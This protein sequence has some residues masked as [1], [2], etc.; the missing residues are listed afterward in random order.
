ME[1]GTELSD[2]P[3][4]VYRNSGNPTYIDNKNY[5]FRVKAYNAYGETAQS[6]PFTPTIID[7]TK[8]STPGIPAVSNALNS[9]FTWT[10]SGSSDSNSGVKGYHIYVGTTPGATDVVDG[11]FVSTNSYTHPTALIPRQR[12]YAFVKAVDNTNNVSGTSSTS[13]QYIARLPRDASI[14]SYSIPSTMEAS[15]AYTVQITVRNEGLETWTSAGGYY[16]GSIEDTD[17]LTLDTRLPLVSTDSIG[18]TQTKT[19]NLSFTGSKNIG[20]YRTEWGMLKLNVGRLGDTLSREVNVVDT[21]PPTGNIIINNG[22]NLTNSPIVSLS[23]GL[24]DNA[25][26]P[27]SQRLKN[28]EL[29]WNEYEASSQ[30]KEWTLSE[31]NG[32][33]TVSVQ[34][35]DPSGNE[36]VV[37]LDTIRLDTSYPTAKLDTPNALDYLNGIVKIIGT[38]S[39]ND[40]KSYQISF[41]EGTSPMTWSVIKTNNSVVDKAVLADWNT[42]G[43][44]TGIYTIRL[45]VEDQAGNTSEERRYVWVD[46]FKNS[47]GMESFWGFV[48]T[49]SAFGQ[50]KVNL[51]NGNLVLQVEDMNLKG[52][53]L[54]TVFNRTYNSQDSTESAL[55]KGWRFNTDTKIVDETNGDIVYI[56]ADGTHHKFTKNAD[57]AFT[58]PIGIFK[59]LKKLADGSYTLSDL[60]SYELVQTFNQNGRL[61]SIQDRNNNKISYL[62]EA[63]LLKEIVDSVGRKISLSYVDNKIDQVTSFTG[64]K[65]KYSY[66]D[67]LLSKVDYINSAGTVYRTIPYSYENGKLKTSTSPRGHKVTYEYNG[68]RVVN[69]K[70][71]LTSISASTG[72]AKEPYTINEGFIYDLTNGKVA[73]S[74]GGPN[75]TTSTEYITNE[76]GNLTSVTE[77]TQGAK[78]NTRYVYQ[79]NLLFENIDGKGLLTKYTYDNRGNILTKTLPTTVDVENGSVTPNISYEY[80]P[81]SSLISKVIDPLTRVTSYEYDDRGNQVSKTDAKGFKEV[82]AYDPFGNLEKTTYERGPLYGRTPN[83]S[84][85]EGETTSVKNWKVNGTWAYDTTNKKSGSRSLVLTN[86]ASLESELVPVKDGRLPARALGY[87]KTENTTGVKTLIQF[88]DASK[89]LISSKESSSITGTND[90]NMQH[91]VSS[92]PTDAEYVSYKIVNQSGN[93]YVDEITL[94]E[95]NYSHTSVYSPDGLNVIESRD[96]Y[97]KKK[98]SE[99]DLTGNKIKETNEL[100]QSATFLYNADNQILESMDRLGKKTVFVYDTNGNLVKETNALGHVVEYQYD[101]RNQLTVTKNPTVTKTFYDYQIAR[102]PEIVSLALVNEYNE[103][104]DKVAES[105]GNQSVILYEYDAMG[106]QVKSIDPLRNELRMTYDENGNKRT[107]E[108][109]AWDNI[110]STLYSKGITHY[111]YDQLNRLTAFSDPTKDQNTLVEK[112]KLDAIGNIVKKTIGSASTEFAFDEYNQSFYSKDSSTPAVETWSH[113]DG[114]GNQ[115]IFLDKLGA[116]TTIHDANGLLKEVVDALGKRTVYTYNAAGDKTKLVD[117]TGTVTNWEYDAEGQLKEERK[118]IINPDTKEESTQI[119]LY[120]YNSL[121]QVTKKIIKESKGLL[122]TTTSKEISYLYDEL[123]RLVKETGKSIDTGFKTESRF[124]HD[125]NG[126]VINTWIYDETN[127]VPIYVDPDKD[128]FF[129]SET[130]SVYDQN[131]RLLRETISHTGTT[132]TNTFDDR[133]NEE[134]LTTSLGN[135]VVTYDNNDRTKQIVTPNFDMF[136]YDYNVDDTLSKVSAPGIETSLTYNGGSKVKT[137]KGIN[138]GNSSSIIDLEYQHSATDQI[139][140]ISENGAVKKKYTY[141]PT[142][143]LE[144]VEA[145]GKVLKYTYDGNSN[146]IQV[147]NL[148]TGKVKEAYTY[149]TGNRILQKKEFNESTGS[150]LRTIDYVHNENGTIS[151]VT[152]KEGS[153]TTVVDYGYN[154]DDQLM[155]INKVVNDQAQPTILYEYDTEGTR[156]AKNVNDGTSNTHYHYHRDTNGNVFLETIEGPTK[157]QRLKYYRDA[158]GNPISFSLDEVVYYYQF[159]A[160][161]D[162][163]AIT[164]AAGNIKATYDYDEWGNV[165]QITGDKALAEANIYRYVGKY[166]VMYDKDTNLYFMGW[167]DYDPTTG[168]FITPDEYEG[169]EEDPTSLNRYLYADADPVNN[170]DPDGHAPKWL[171]KGWKATKKYSKSAYNLAIGDDINTLRNP[172]A[173]W[174]QKAGAT[175]SIASNFVPGAG[176]AKW[177]V[178]GAVAGVKYGK[179]AK[180]VQKLASGSVKDEKKI[181]SNPNKSTGKVHKNSNDYVGHQGVYEIKKDGKLHKYGKADMTSTSSTGLPK[182]LQSQLNKLQKQNPD[183]QVMGRVIYDN[184]SI[185]TRVIKKIE[186]KAVQNYYDKYKQYPQGNKNHPGLKE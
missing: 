85:E 60:D 64:T 163:I 93:V 4:S 108:N 142:G 51:A 19:Y 88:Y 137:I 20:S 182:R 63:N 144:T 71:S 57:E 110:T 48:D 122:S 169:T 118:T 172:K 117:A 79:N 181:R 138:R 47:L 90:W 74:E 61:S 146:I 54:N 68:L 111:R 22:A 186:T 67:S 114:M 10:W 139:T 41:G 145:N 8:P 76:N 105:D 140:Q 157:V 149:S 148:T 92:I 95:S 15:G 160:R 100:N 109:L 150:L 14:N 59:E 173:K 62:Y 129:N 11:S 99:Y 46:P 36:S 151:K 29:A 130:V 174:Y 162:V 126:N 50:S 27:F 33:K 94:E 97:G 176:Q 45:L 153:S 107:E 9:A 103:L 65:I 73:F 147:D 115:A 21:I 168:R 177:A 17:P 175:L 83:F 152:T 141:T 12:Y 102:T 116:T 42:S 133:K 37:S 70:S 131:N 136:T 125:N 91:I 104:G 124:Y 112:Y 72:L 128:G 184:K 13:N 52:R 30:S 26:G 167:R 134:T 77:D 120:E 44:T 31:G 58:S 34:Y 179:K 165:I 154:S 24:T 1:S 161:G 69:V 55:G 158:S 49:E 84:F 39:D 80:K 18:P 180:K 171:Q 38:A 78:I 101:E 3:R 121:G 89:Q 6:E 135:T 164:D 166:G 16:L 56:D 127:P 53:G 43:I 35:K 7:Q 86:A 32:D 5:W 2:D 87:V 75:V 170:I 123:G 66:T 159:N 143:N 82:L 178:K 28:E 183:S 23:L 40:L 132:T 81:N 185:S 106:R 25:N 156:I 96:P 155:K 119:V 113:Y 98:V